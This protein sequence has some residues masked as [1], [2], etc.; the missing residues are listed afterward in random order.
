M[1]EG[2]LPNG[3]LPP[4]GFPHPQPSW[5]DYGRC[6]WIAIGKLWINDLL[7]DNVPG[8]PPPLDT[9]NKEPIDPEQPDLT[10]TPD[11]T[12]TKAHRQIVGVENAG[13]K[14][15]GKATG[16]NNMHRKYSEQWNPWHPFRSAYDFQQAQLFSQQTKTW[17]DQHLRC[18]LD[19]FKI[20]FFQSSDA[21][22]QLLSELDFG[23]GDD[24]W[25]EDDSHIF[26]PLYYRDIFK[27]IQFLLAHLPLQKHHDFKPV[28]LADSKGHHIYSE[29]NTGDWWWD[30]LD[31]LPARAMIVPVICASNKT[32]L[33]NFLDDQHS[34]LLYF[35]ISYSRKDIGWTP[36]KQAWIHVCLIPCPLK[37][38]KN[39]DEAWHSMVGT[40]LS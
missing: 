40:V 31:Q 39:M 6:T 34:W 4:A 8:A 2:L 19:N 30:T 25:I 18:G 20:Q 26:G 21:M 3:I 14:A 32:H 5:F 27:R 11:L 23:L 29:M 37:G 33:T 17:I 22:Q 16:L 9:P 28:R 7:I 38:A 10:Y 15:Y 24:S 12:K 36:K 35:L 1:N 13:G